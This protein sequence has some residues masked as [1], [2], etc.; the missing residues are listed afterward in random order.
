MARVIAKLTKTIEE[1]DMQI[2]SLINN[3]E[4]QVQNIGESSQGLN[5]LPNVASPPDDAPHASKAMQVKG[6]TTKS[7]SVASLSVQ[8]LQD[9]ITN[10]IR[11]QYDGA[12]HSLRMPVGYQPPK[13]QSFNGKGNPKQHVPISSKLVTMQV[14]MVTC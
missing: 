1:K 4:A 9:M 7:T 5:H 13:F 6:Q 3:I 2:V 14:Q 10:T 11:A 12:S 8:Q